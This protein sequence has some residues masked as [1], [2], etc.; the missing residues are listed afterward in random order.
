LEKAN[1]NFQKHAAAAMV[2]SEK[3][4]GDAFESVLD[5]TYIS[6]EKVKGVANFRNLPGSTRKPRAKQLKLE[7]KQ[8]FFLVTYGLFKKNE[9]Y[10][11]EFRYKGK[12]RRLGV[13]SIKDE[14]GN[15][16]FPQLKPIIGKT[17]TQKPGVVYNMDDNPNVSIQRHRIDPYLEEK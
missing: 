11:D 3:I 12:N 16:T 17:V 15:E 8:T 13:N 1:E 6:E 7:S 14:E 5:G 10:Y 2:G 4:L 9:Y